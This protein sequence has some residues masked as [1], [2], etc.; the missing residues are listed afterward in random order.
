M[1]SFS[2]DS[3]ESPSVA[4]AGSMVGGAASHAHMTYTGQLGTSSGLL[5]QAGVGS[6]SNPSHQHQQ[7]MAMVGSSVGHHQRHH[8]AH[9]HR[10]YEPQQQPQPQSQQQQQHYGQQQSQQ[11]NYNQQQHQQ[12]YLQQYQQQQQQHY[13]QTDNGNDNNNTNPS[14][15]MISTSGL[16]TSDAVERSVLP[17][18]ALVTSACILHLLISPIP[19]CTKLNCSSC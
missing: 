6:G 15:Y 5:D 19:A 11:P 10:S 17:L 7:A 13:R 8:S 14:D 9:H 18:I 12:R 16:M 2:L 4:G 1:K 3:P